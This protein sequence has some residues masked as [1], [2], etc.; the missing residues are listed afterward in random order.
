MIAIRIAVIALQ[1]VIVGIYWYKQFKGCSMGEKIW[2]YITSYAYCATPGRFIA[3]L[4]LSYQMDHEQL[5]A[6]ML[7]KAYHPLDVI[8]PLITAIFMTQWLSRQSAK[9]QIV[10]EEKV[11]GFVGFSIIIYLVVSYLIILQLDRT[12]EQDRVLLLSILGLIIGMVTVFSRYHIQRAWY[13]VVDTYMETEVDLV[14]IRRVIQNKEAVMFDMIED[15]R[16]A[17]PMKREEIEACIEVI[18]N[19]AFIKIGFSEN[20]ILNAL[21]FQYYIRF[22]ESN[23][24][25][26]TRVTPKLGIDTTVRAGKTYQFVESWLSYGDSQDPQKIT[27]VT[28]EIIRSE[29]RLQIQGRIY[30]VFK[31]LDVE[32]QRLVDWKKKVECDIVQMRSLNVAISPNLIEMET[33]I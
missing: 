25:F 15:L 26:T 30:G 17:L 9:E 4:L 19:E 23:I 11:Y 24:E 33:F 6:V 16:Q 20:D 2:L 22:M 27:R 7:W 1:C 13:Q 10:S 12:V 18:K 5:K 28:M 3:L 31:N 29:D 32:R 21:I 8:I 14:K